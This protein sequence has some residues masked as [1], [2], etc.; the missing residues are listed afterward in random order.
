MG[1]FAYALAETLARNEII[2]QTA[3]I[4]LNWP[5]HLG[6]LD[7]FVAT[8][9]SCVGKSRESRRPNNIIDCLLLSTTS[10][11]VIHTSPIDLTRKMD[12]SQAHS[13]RKAYTLSRQLSIDS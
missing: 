12:P 3:H 9:L 7:I 6:S 5:I 13:S 11:F 4:E 10:L 1:S 2:A 8:S